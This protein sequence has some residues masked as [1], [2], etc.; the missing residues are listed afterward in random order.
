MARR[1][2]ELKPDKVAYREALALYLL[3]KQETNEAMAA[4]ADVA[5]GQHPIYL[6]LKDQKAVLVP[7]NAI[8][9]PG[10]SESMAELQMRMKYG[11]LR[12]RFYVLPMSAAE[13]EKFYANYWNS[14]KL[15]LV[16]EGSLGNSGDTI[17]PAEPATRIFG[18]FL[19]ESDGMLIPSTSA[20]GEDEAF[21]EGILFSVIE[22]SG[23]PP[24]NGLE[25]P[26]GYP[27]PA[28]IGDVYCYL[29]IFNF[30]SYE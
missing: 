27:L 26:A 1:A 2:V 6:L 17:T 25:T 9:S 15:F 23:V 30:R 24:E 19:R 29:I 10:D 20:P 28:D 13:V 14:F 3:G 16:Y 5:D 21:E 11:R 12:V 8:Y 4:L 18:Q 22:F 7:D